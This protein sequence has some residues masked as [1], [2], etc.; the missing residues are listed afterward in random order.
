[1][2]KQLMSLEIWGRPANHSAITSDP[3]CSRQTP[4]LRPRRVGGPTLPATPAT[5]TTRTLQRR[6]RPA[7][8]PSPSC[9]PSVEG[10]P[11]PPP[12]LLSR[13]S[14][15]QLPSRSRRKARA[16]A[17]TRASA[18]RTWTRGKRTTDGP[19]SP[20]SDGDRNCLWE[21]LIELSS[22]GRLEILYGLPMSVRGDKR[23]N[24]WF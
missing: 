17:A 22:E 19:R 24:C 15:E 14:R 6:S 2:L 5:T 10:P 4:A 12:S 13:L 11:P 3:N 18:R 23:S 16:A 7:A 9:S 20:G 1:M 21:H 8:S